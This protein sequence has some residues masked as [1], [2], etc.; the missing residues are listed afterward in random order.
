M[1]PKD[2]FQNHSTG[3]GQS[4]GAQLLST[5]QNRNTDLGC[6]KE[7][8]R[9]P[10]GAS[11]QHHLALVPPP[12]QH[13]SEAL[14][15]SLLCSETFYDSPQPLDKSQFHNLF[16]A[17]LSRL[18]SNILTGNSNK[19]RPQAHP[20]LHHVLNSPRTCVEPWFMFSLSVDSPT[21]HSLSLSSLKV[22][23]LIQPSF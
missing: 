19:L 20:I 5:H 16:L 10:A 13:S 11:T 23:S 14:S 15:R 12:T 1:N 3:E 17:S 22:S 8:Q 6:A 18:F 21:P 9:A 2:L 4:W 7:A